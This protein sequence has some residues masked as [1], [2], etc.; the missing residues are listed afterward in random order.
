MRK[1]HL[2]QLRDC[3]SHSGIK[4]FWKIECDALTDEDVNALA[5]MLSERIKFSEVFGVPRGGIRIEQALKKYCKA[6]Y[7]ILIVDD[8]LT[9]GTSMIE[10]KEKNKL[11]AAIGAVIFARGICPDW[12]YP[13]FQLND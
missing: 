3:L 4:M 5:F 9:T 13:L 7:P 11:I 10:F 8:V 12:V 2:F 1:K 6:G